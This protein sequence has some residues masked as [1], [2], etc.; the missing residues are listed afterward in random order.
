MSRISIGVAE[1]G[2]KKNP[3]YNIGTRHRMDPVQ[4]RS[5]NPLKNCRTNFTHSGVFFVDVNLFC[6]CFVMKPAMSEKTEA[7]H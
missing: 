6:P 1:S 7:Q 5:E 3:F 4:R 2:K